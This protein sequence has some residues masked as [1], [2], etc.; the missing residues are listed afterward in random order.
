MKT[1]VIYKGLELDT[2]LRL[3]LFVEGILPIELKAID[4][5]LPIYEAQ[6]LTYMKLLKVPKGILMNFNVNNIFKEGQ[7]TFVNELYRNL[8]D[9]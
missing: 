1:P 9:K 8:K 4:A 3:D 7:R 5:I 2:E 6:I